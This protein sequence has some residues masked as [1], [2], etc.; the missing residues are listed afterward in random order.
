[1]KRII[2][3]LIILM[4]SFSAISVYAVEA[5][6]IY[7]E[8]KFY[9]ATVYVCDVENSRIILRNVK[10]ENFMDGLLGAREIEYRAVDVN[11][12]CLFDKNGNKLTLEQINGAFLDVE[13]TVLTGRNKSGQR[14]LYI[15]F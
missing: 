1:M 5:E 11:E 2:S 3:T 9:S 14:V 10:P 13:A 8:Y 7:T 4:L 6:K 12:N 15:K